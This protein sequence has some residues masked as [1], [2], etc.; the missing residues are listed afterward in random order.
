[1][2]QWW[3]LVRKRGPKNLRK[4]Y[5]VVVIL[6]H[7]RIW[8]ERNSR[9]FDSVHYSAE[10]VFEMIKEEIRAWRAAGRVTMM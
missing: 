1:M 10:D 3:L 9:V 4:D 5:D 6:M 7:W 8:K 2:E